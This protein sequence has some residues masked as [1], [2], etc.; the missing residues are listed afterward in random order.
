MFASQYSITQKALWGYKLRQF[1]L[2]RGPWYYFLFLVHLQLKA[3]GENNARFFLKKFELAY[4]IEN[5]VKANAHSDN[6]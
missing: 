2:C 1:L 3:C 6:T 4:F 5:N